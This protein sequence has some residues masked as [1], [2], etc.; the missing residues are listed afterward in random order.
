VAEVIELV[1]YPVK[2]CAGTS[3]PEAVVTPAGI[4][5]DR[6]FMIIDDDGLFR[7]QRKDPRM[8][9]ILPEISVDG[10]QL[11]LHA[12]DIESVRID[13]DITSAR[14]A[15][16]MFSDPY[17]GIDQGSV[18]A[19]WLS[20]VLGVPSRLVRVP[21]EHNRVTNGQTPGT[22]GFAD[23]TAILLTSP[24]SLDFLNKQMAENGGGLL[25]MDRFRPNV[26]VDG[27]AEPHTEDRVRQVRIGDVELGY[28]KLDMRCVVTTVDQKSGV[29]EGPEPLRTLAEY[30]R[31][32][33]GVAF[34]SMFAV[35]RPGRL[36]VGDEVDVSSWGESDL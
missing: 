28:A 18:A 23:A 3:T 10:A 5:H 6:T 19:D 30:R 9:V 22:C 2:G 15:V 4:A 31:S 26:V 21:P 1:Y 8:A 16:T 24:A 12:P 33:G 20:E 13:V 36:A 25:P 35:T 32:G 11:T 27:W 7:S 34:G 14:R 29:K 17:Q